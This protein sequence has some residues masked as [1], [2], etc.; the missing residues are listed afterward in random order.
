MHACD[1]FLVIL[2]IIKGVFG[3]RC[4]VGW[5][6]FLYYVG[7]LSLSSTLSF[8]LLNHI[9]TNHYN[10]QNRKNK[11]IENHGKGGHEA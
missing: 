8:S 10:S 7:W 3:M 5:F 9:E 4:V 6:P 11:R 2:L 1:D